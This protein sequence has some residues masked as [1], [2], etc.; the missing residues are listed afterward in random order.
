MLNSILNSIGYF[1][2][3][4]FLIYFIDPFSYGYLFGALLIISIITDN[5]FIEKLESNFS[6]LFLFSICYATFYVFNLDLG[7]QFILIY[8]LFPVGFYLIGKTFNNKS[9][10]N[11]QLFYLLF[12]SGFIFSLP[13]MVSVLTSIIDKGFVVIER[14]VPMIWGGN[15]IPA[16]NMAA[17]FVLNMS[18]PAFLVAGFKKFNLPLKLLMISTFIISVLCVLRLGSRTQLSIFFITFIISLI[19]LIRRQTVKQNVTLFGIL[20]L[21]FNVFLSYVSFDKDSDIMSAFAGR[22]ESKKYGAAT[23]GGRTE[24][25]T[26]SIVNLWEK[27]LGWDVTDFGFS[28]NLWFDI[29]RVGGTLSFI[30]LLIFTIKNAVNIKKAI[31]L[32][33]QNA[34]LNTAFICYGLSFYLLFFV[35]PIFDGY[36]PLFV[37]YCFFLGIIAQYNINNRAIK[38]EQN[39]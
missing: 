29:A 8:A 16:T 20:F 9:L 10:N 34:L 28:H 5:F 36:F 19:F 17:Y 21:I 1:R 25:W 24:R 6:L 35:E 7:S 32:I 26:K 37:F 4:L 3:I 39:S 18:I 33:P 27:P 30:L 2:V 11:I 38:N 14:D 13:A 22:M 23:A 31:L 15:V 12:A